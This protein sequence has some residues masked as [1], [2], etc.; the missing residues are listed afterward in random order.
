MLLLGAGKLQVRCLGYLPGDLFLYRKDVRRLAIIM[1]TPD[2]RPI[3][4]SHQF[5][6]DH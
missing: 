4:D 5:G 1:V 3:R 6:L 2:L